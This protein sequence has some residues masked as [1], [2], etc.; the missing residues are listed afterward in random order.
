MSISHEAIAACEQ[1]MATPEQQRLCAKAFRDAWYM[2][3]LNARHLG[4]LTNLLV[5]GE[6]LSLASESM[7]KE[8][9][10]IESWFSSERRTRL[11]QNLENATHRWQTQRSIRQ[12]AKKCF[13]DTEDVR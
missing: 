8:R 5:A 12:N 4:D 11:W 13:P 7:M 10:C 1:G 3:G 6:D 9:Y 2:E